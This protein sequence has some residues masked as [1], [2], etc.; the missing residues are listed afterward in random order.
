MYEEATSLLW[1]TNT[2]SF[3]D[4]ISFKH[5][6]RELKTYQRE[7]LAA[8][9]IDCSITSLNFQCPITFVSPELA[10]TLP[11]L[12]TLHMTLENKWYGTETRLPWV[13]MNSDQMKDYLSTLKRLPLKHVSVSLSHDLRDRQ[14]GADPDSIETKIF[15]AEEVRLMLLRSK[16]PLTLCD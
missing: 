9:H 1:T 11:S 7:R 2:F 10:K 4:E 16:N 8:I 12:H 15:I 6:V 3:E 5:F 14:G 13:P